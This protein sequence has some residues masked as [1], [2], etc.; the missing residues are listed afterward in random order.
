MSTIVSVAAQKYGG[1]SGAVLLLKL[2][3]RSKNVFVPC[4]RTPLGRILDGRV[5]SGVDLWLM[6]SV[7]GFPSMV[8]W[9][10]LLGLLWSAVLLVVWPLG[11]A[12]LVHW[13]AGPPWFYRLG[14]SL[15]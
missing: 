13:V 1:D 7:F 2:G 5:L 6:L 14:D 4:L 10:V 12:D 3:V 15:R 9:S 11:V 8:G